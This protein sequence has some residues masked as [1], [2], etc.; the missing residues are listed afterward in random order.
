M[1][2]WQA[3]FP[4]QFGGTDCGFT[5]SQEELGEFMAES[6]Y[7]PCGDDH[8]QAHFEDLQRQSGLMQPLT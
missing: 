8:L 6:T 3:Y 1:S 5:V 2:N 7:S 4:S